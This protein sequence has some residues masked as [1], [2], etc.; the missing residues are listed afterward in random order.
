MKRHGNLFEKI[1][2]LDNLLLAH[3]NAKRGKAHYREVKKIEKNPVYYCE[4]L[5]AMLENGE[6]T[7]SK[8][9]VYEKLCGRKK[10][11]IYRL[12]YFPDRIVQHAIM[13][14]LEPIWR[15]T[16]IRDTFQSIKGRGTHDTRKRI[17]KVLKNNKLPFALQMDIKKF[18]PSVNNSMLKNTV[19]RKIKCSK[20][21]KL[22]DNI[23]DSSKGLPV[24]NYTSQIL[25]NVYLST[26]DW[27]A[28]QKLKLKYYFRYCDD[29]L[30]LSG[31]KVFLHETKTKIIKALSLLTL[32]IN[33]NNRVS[34]TDDGIAFI[35]F[36]FYPNQLKL[37]RRNSDSFKKKIKMIKRNH[38]RVSTKSKI[39]SVM[40]YWGMIKHCN[41][42]ALWNKYFD[43]E[44]QIKLGT[45]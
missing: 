19:R 32:Q 22:L 34:R 38:K 16:F 14:I 1:V 45:L 10:R 30:V 37:L 12:P 17:Q 26:L 20:T 35:G 7:T 31:D 41:A 11:M 25:G 2:D 40:S 27:F 29:I 8:Y 24:G 39:S 5:K 36:R 18:Y 4:K 6:F 15:K 42:K 13:Q 28:K 44:L 33:K 23:I 21:L 9:T 43:K 3:Q